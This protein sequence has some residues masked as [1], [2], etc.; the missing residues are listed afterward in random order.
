[1]AITDHNKK[2]IE[3]IKKIRLEKNISQT[4]I[5]KHL[6]LS[7]SNYNRLEN[8]KIQL[9]IN[10]LYAI[11]EALEVKDEELLGIATTKNIH[12]NNNVV[13]SQFFNDGVLHLSIS[14][15]ELKKESSSKKVEKLS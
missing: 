14:T 1:M 10:N 5:A 15:D 4:H 8:N 12:N 13:V 11:A 2:V 7:V 9:T 6:Q 3:N